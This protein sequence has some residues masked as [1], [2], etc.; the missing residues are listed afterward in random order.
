MK[1]S[2]EKSTC[3]ARGSGLLVEVR[4]RTRDLLRAAGY[5]AYDIARRRPLADG[6]TPRANIAFTLR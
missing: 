6:A 3:A 4:K 2:L 5:V 1:A